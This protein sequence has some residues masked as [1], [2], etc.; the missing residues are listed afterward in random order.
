MPPKDW[1]S[2]RTTR[3]G[4]SATVH[5]TVAPGWSRPIVLPVDDEDAAPIGRDLNRDLLVL[6]QDQAAVQREVRGHR[7]E[8]HGAQ[9]GDR[10]GPPADRL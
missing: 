9:V 7:R 2:L 6:G 3:T 1:G 10:I 8:H 4:R 5:V